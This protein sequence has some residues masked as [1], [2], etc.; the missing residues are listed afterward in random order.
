VIRLA[1]M[2]PS[3]IDDIV[4]VGGATRVPMVR[5]R[6]EQYFGKTPHANI[7]PDEVVAYGAAV[8][9]VALSGSAET[10]AFHSLLLDVTPRALGIAVAGGFSERVVERNVQIPLEQTRIFTTSSDNQQLV[11][12]QVCQGESR[13]FDENTGLGELVLPGLRPARRGDI[14]VAV[15]FLVNTDGIL[16]VSARDVDTGAVQQATMQVRGTMAESD[17]ATKQA[18]FADGILEGLPEPGEPA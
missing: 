6:V 4:L 15:T 10:D 14:K 5:A 18:A 8:Q 17:I 7:N 12:I 3:D 1:G 13:R 11:R 2:Q 9:A 16:Q